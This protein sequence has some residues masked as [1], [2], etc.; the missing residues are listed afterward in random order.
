[1]PGSQSALRLHTCC[2]QPQAHNGHIGS[3]TVVQINIHIV[4]QNPLGIDSR[5]TFGQ[6]LTFLHAVTHKLCAS[7]GLRKIDMSPNF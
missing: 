7:R 5:D 4:S 1:M 3:A 6:L 2:L